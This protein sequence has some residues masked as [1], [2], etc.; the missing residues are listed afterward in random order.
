MLNFIKDILFPI[1]CLFC[2]KYGAWLCADC[3]QDINETPKQ[4]CPKCKRLNDWGEL[5]SDCR[6]T[7][8]LNGI[9]VAGDYADKK[10]SDLIKKYKYNFLKGLGEILADFVIN[11]LNKKI[12]TN[13]HH[14]ILNNA[15]KIRRDN[16]I[17]M[18]VPLSRRRQ[19]WRGFNQSEIISDYIAV[20]LNI[21]T[22]KDL[23]RIKNKKPQAQLD[24]KHRRQNL[25]KT[26]IWNGANLNNKKIILVDDVVTTGTT[27]NECAEVLKA[28]GAAEVWGLVIAGRQ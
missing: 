12:F 18:P 22:G 4:Y 27:L 16:I 1:E 10:L 5:C 26:F 8:H 24:E 25:A 23:K 28:A 15:L 11:F 2:K 13:Q 6:G 7:L 20:K 14:A 19:R 17:I 9:W 3:A 21:E